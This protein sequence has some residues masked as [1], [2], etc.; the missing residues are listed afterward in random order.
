MMN[1]AWRKGYKLGIITSSDHGSTHISYA[2]VYSPDPSRQGI[3]D[4]IRRRHTYGATDNIVLDVRMGSH[5][6]GDEVALKKALPLKVRARGTGEVARVD[7][8]KDSQIVYTAE[9]KSRDVHFE[10]I[11]KG[12]VAAR[13][14]Y[15]VRVLQT[16]GMIARSSPFFVNYK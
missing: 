7:V 11:N 5:F 3:V 8:I 16:D 2:M 4:A 12:D 1:L 6:R 9:P 13:H 15:Y 10:F 14:Y